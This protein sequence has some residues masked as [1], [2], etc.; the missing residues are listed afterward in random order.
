MKK[1]YITSSVILIL[2]ITLSAQ[3]QFWDEINSPEGGS[4]TYIGMT[5][6]SGGLYAGD[7]YSSNFWTYDTDAAIWSLSDSKIRPIIHIV[8]N[9][10]GRL[11]GKLDQGISSQGYAYSDD[12]G[13]TWEPLKTFQNIDQLWTSP[14]GIL[15]G[16]GDGVVKVSQDEGLSWV[17]SL[18][19]PEGIYDPMHIGPE[20]QLFIKNSDRSYLISTDQGATWKESYFDKTYSA[21][22]Y[23]SVTA[24]LFNQSGDV[25][26]F[27]LIRNNRSIYRSS[28]NG[29]IWEISNFPYHCRGVQIHKSG[30]LFATTQTLN[31][32][33]LRSIDKGDTWSML[34]LPKEISYVQELILKEDAIYLIDGSQIYLSADLGDTWTT[35]GK[36]PENSGN[37]L[38]EDDGTFLVTSYDEGIFRSIDFGL[39][40]E[41]FG[42]G[43]N[44]HEIDNVFKDREGKLYANARFKKPHMSSDGGK[45]W[46]YL[47]DPEIQNIQGDDNGNLYAL[48]GKDYNTRH[49][50]FSDD[51]GHT[52]EDVKWNLINR[53]TNF[54]IDNEDFLTVFTMGDGSHR[55]QIFR[56]NDFGDTWQVI[57]PELTDGDYV[58]IS[59]FFVTQGGNYLLNTYDSFD[60]VHKTYLSED[61][62]LTWIQLPITAGRFVQNS[63]GRIYTFFSYRAWFS[64]N[65]SLYYSDDN[66]ITWDLLPLEGEV[67]FNSLPEYY[68]DANANFYA[69][70]NDTLRYSSDAGNSWEI[71]SIDEI[72]TSIKNISFTNDGSMFAMTVFNKI[73]NGT[74]KSGVLGSRYIISRKLEISTYPN[75]FTAQTSLE[76]ELNNPFEVRIEVIDL[77]GNSVRKLY[78]GIQNPGKHLL[79]WN[80]TDNEGKTVCSGIYFYK[81]RIGEQ[82]ETRRVI[83]M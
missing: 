30:A 70:S 18:V 33:L 2:S 35:K 63:V 22:D 68:F 76:Y 13:K 57:K 59:N 28:D 45:S 5:T 29:Q 12:T 17:E 54:S 82:M 48:K 41:Y 83:V 24:P 55:E 9:R 80:R 1:A 26:F 31:S 53:P 23:F 56:T 64:Y 73:Y 75:P 77:N 62:G 43:I 36:L 27:S 71:L 8:E 58:S 44:N 11:Y 42:Q 81:I 61:K 46:T 10:S 65:A 21:D 16:S 38:V 15:Y 72:N 3:I 25:F 51:Q 40:W 66:G 32:A 7:Y 39:S 14:D 52:W 60:W 49:I 20:G 67:S 6:Q 19:L 78:E 50:V 4:I 79:V 37:I 47:K 69:L 74:S 34:S